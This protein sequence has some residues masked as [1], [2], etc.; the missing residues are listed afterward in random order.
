MLADGTVDTMSFSEKGKDKARDGAKKLRP[1]PMNEKNRKRIDEWRSYIARCVP[2]ELHC[3]TSVDHGKS[4][5]YFVMLPL[6]QCGCRR[7][8]MATY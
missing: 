5:A 2:L 7:E 8:D 6:V 3:E 1:N 4:I